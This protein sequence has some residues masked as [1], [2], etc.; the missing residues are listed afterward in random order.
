MRRMILGGLVAALTAIFMFAAA[1][2]AQAQGPICF[3]NNSGCAV[4]VR[5]TL[6]G[7]NKIYDAGTVA[8]GATV[9]M[10][11]SGTVSALYLNNSNQGLNPPAVGACVSTGLNCPT[12]V[13]RAGGPP[14]TFVFF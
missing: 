2:E 11:L 5:F 13:C 4:S 10:N 8:A 1:P 6:Q 7:Q 12:D 9:C 3:T 14:N